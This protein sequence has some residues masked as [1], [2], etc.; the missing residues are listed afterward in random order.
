MKWK[1]LK[2][3]SQ[4]TIRQ[5]QTQA[6]KSKQTLKKALDTDQSLSTCPASK[7]DLSVLSAHRRWLA[8]AICLSMW[9]Q[10]ILL[11]NF[12][13]KKVRGNAPYVKNLTQHMPPW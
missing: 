2:L 11:V 5:T 6:V 3:K 12:Q 13:L 8:T 7:R 9:H 10:Y 4:T 1:Q